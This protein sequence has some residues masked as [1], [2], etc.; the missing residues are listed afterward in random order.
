LTQAQNTDNRQWCSGPDEKP[1]SSQTL[2]LPG[3]QVLVSAP[4]AGFHSITTCHNHISEQF[5]SLFPNLV[6]GARKDTHVC[7]R[8]ALRHT[9]VTQDTVITRE[10]VRSQVSEVPLRKDTEPLQNASSWPC[11][12]HREYRFAH[13]THNRARWGSG[14]VRSRQEAAEGGS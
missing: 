10:S 9:L 14:P 12:T 3:T 4:R 2:P 6:N 7:W 11:A 1:P 5:P 13:A 8:W